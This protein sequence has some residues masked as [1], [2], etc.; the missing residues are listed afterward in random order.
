M[1]TLPVKIGD[2]HILIFTASL[3]EGRFRASEVPLNLTSGTFQRIA[4][5]LN[6][7]VLLFG[8]RSLQDHS[9]SADGTEART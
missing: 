5:A 3:V 4:E 9:I 2:T 8:L 7:E 1:R 6:K